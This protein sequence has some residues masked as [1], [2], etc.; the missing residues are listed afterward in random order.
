MS[1]PRESLTDP[2]A[3]AASVALTRYYRWHARLYD[4]TRWSFLFGRSRLIQAIAAHRQ[5]RRI[6]EI[7]CGTGG[8][9]LRLLRQFPD[10]TLIGLDLSADMLAQA[11][12][13][14]SARSAPI[15]LLQ[16]RYDR[17][18]QLDTPLDLIVFSYCLSMI[19]PG[20]RQAV[21]AALHD[22]RA[23]GLLAVVDFHDTPS[24]RFNRWMALNHVR[25]NAHLLPHLNG[26]CQPITQSVRPA[27]GGG[28]RYFSFIG[29][30][31]ND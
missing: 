6:L 27:Y 30:K 4:S 28:W 31:R 20:W 23:G 17:P 8:N 26:R 9:L 7:G 14:A 2:A 3:E 25:M 16:R 10:A 22:L 1:E 21:A 11:R 15:T 13:K 24:A 29:S 5:P 19:N 18:L 12:R